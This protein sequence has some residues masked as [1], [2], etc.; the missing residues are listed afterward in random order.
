M[1]VLE[2]HGLVQ[3]LGSIY[4][5]GLLE[6]IDSSELPK[7]LG[8]SC[9]CSD[10]GGC[11]GSNKGSWNDPYILKLIHNLEAGC[12]REIKPVSEGEE[13]NSSSFRL[14]QMKVTL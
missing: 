7:F 10:K 4:Q 8:G 3:V 13:R 12:T 14:E 11:L 5:S 6:V 2:T 1:P 9:T